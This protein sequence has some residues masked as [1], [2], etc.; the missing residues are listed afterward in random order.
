MHVV[1]PEDIE[2]WFMTNVLSYGH[3]ITDH[4][5]EVHFTR[6]YV[7]CCLEW[8]FN[9]SHPCIVPLFENA[10]DVGSY[11]D[12][13]HS[14]DFPP[15]PLH[16]LIITDQQWLLKITLLSDNLIGLTNP[17]MRCMFW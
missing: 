2:I 5:E 13:G 15:S 6:Q 3:A 1:P 8:Y 12:G 4:V 7:D 14:N 16:L 17:E 10:Y 9:V 11:N